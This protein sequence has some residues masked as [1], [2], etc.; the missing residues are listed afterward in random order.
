MKDSLFIAS[1]IALFTVGGLLM[2]KRKR[3]PGKSMSAN[4]QQDELPRYEHEQQK[5]D[6]FLWVPE[7]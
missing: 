6:G 5:R 3:K 7:N 4:W 2:W 1:I